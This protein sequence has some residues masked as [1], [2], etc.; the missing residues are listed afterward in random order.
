MEVAGVLM[1]IAE[2][3]AG[4][5]LF[6]AVCAGLGILGSQFYNRRRDKREVR[7]IKREQQAADDIASER[8]IGLI[9]RE[10]DKRVQIVRAE[11]ELIIATLKL[12]QAVAMNKM[13]ADF[14]KQIAE[15]R[16]AGETFRCDVAP[17]CEHRHHGAPKDLP[18]I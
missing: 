16:A 4:V 12:E 9:E 15:V 10:A 14:D 7:V 2:A 8:L 11:F 17:D 6:G 18:T 3:A 13:R 1:T 5:S